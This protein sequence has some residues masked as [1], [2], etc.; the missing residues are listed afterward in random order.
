MVMV[1]FYDII[2]RASYKQNKV[3][4]D[5]KSWQIMK[6]DFTNINISSRQDANN[7]KLIEQL[8]GC[9]IA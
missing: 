9:T 3:N 2:Y 5:W 4:K 7:L 1:R 8:K 6:K